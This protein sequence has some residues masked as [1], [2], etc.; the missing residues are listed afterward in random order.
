MIGLL[1]TERQAEGKPALAIASGIAS[2]EVIAGHTV[3]QARAPYTCIGDTVDLAA[4]LEAH[5]QQAG[6]P[7]LL[8]GDTAAALAGRLPL[9]A[10]GEVLFKGKSAPVAVLALGRLPR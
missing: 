1:N 2:G 3:T 9:L 4:R 8:C 5:T 7:I 10:L 6:Q